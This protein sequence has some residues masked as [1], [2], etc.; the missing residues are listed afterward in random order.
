[1]RGCMPFGRPWFVL[2]S[3]VASL[4]ILVLASPAGATF[5]PGEWPD[6]RPGDGSD[7]CSEEEVDGRSGGEH[8]GCSGDGPDGCSGGGSGGWF[9][10]WLGIS[11]RE[12]TD[13]D[14]ED[15]SFSSLDGSFSFSGFD[16][17]VSGAARARA[18]S[19]ANPF[20][21][22][23]STCAEPAGE[24]LARSAPPLRLTPNTD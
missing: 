3:L 5:S 11:L 7:G 20:A 16:A 9:E 15:D 10:D 2:K 22:R 1:V 21:L 12:L 24:A 14:G 23:L 17:E 19:F 13:G 4:A 18:G 6:G 8:D